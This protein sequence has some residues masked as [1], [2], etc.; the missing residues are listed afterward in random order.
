MVVVD[1]ASLLYS[2]LGNKPPSSSNSTG[3]VESEDTDVRREVEAGNR[4]DAS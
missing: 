4:V 3:D 1:T 2:V